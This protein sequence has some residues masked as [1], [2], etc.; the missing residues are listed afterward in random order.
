MERSA[1]GRYDFR[2]KD[3]SAFD[4]SSIPWA[5]EEPDNKGQA[6]NNVVIGNPDSYTGDF[7]WRDVDD[8][9]ARFI[10]ERGATSGLTINFI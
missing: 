5:D 8:I 3:G 9:E 10:C 2:W 6:E 7:E 4:N 1:S